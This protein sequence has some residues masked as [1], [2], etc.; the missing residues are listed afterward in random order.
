MGK[1]KKER[2]L[3]EGIKSRKKTRFGQKKYIGFQKVQGEE[4][5][6]KMDERIYG[7]YEIERITGEMGAK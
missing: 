5:M 4:K 1:E 3:M 6:R 2:D 7:S